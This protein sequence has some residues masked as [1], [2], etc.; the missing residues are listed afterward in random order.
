M[1]QEFV[2][3][4]LK[5][6]FT[7][8][9]ILGHLYPTRPFVVEVNASEARV[10]AVLSQYFAE[11]PKLHPVVFFPVSCLQL[12]VTMTGNRELLAVKITLEE[13]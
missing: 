13:W 10:G 6:A 2:F 1:L 7:T 11:K 5:T 8:A 3:R 9:P 12:N 4:K